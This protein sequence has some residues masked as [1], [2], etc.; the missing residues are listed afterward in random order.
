MSN[1]DFNDK[2]NKGVKNLAENN[3]QKDQNIK[4]RNYTGPTENVMEAET[5]GVNF[6]IPLINHTTSIKRDSKVGE[7]I[8]SYEDLGIKPGSYSDFQKDSIENSTRAREKNVGGIESVKAPH[9]WLMG[10]GAI[11]SIAGKVIKYGVNLVDKFPT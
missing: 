5:T 1:G 2:V 9:E 10:G 3:K 4:R 7:E 6:N 11:K 8:S